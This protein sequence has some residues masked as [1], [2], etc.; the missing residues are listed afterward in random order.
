MAR[1]LDR[2]KALLGHQRPR[3]LHL[4]LILCAEGRQAIDLD[5]VRRE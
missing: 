3:L 4:R 2:Q 1:E 5:G